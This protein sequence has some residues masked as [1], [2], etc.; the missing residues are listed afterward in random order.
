MDE[1]LK[2]AKDYSPIKAKEYLD[3]YVIKQ[4]KAKIALSM[5]LHSHFKNLKL[6]AINDYCSTMTMSVPRNITFLIGNTG[7]GKSHSIKTL[8][9]YAKL[10][11]VYIDVSKIQ[12]DGYNG[13]NLVSKFKDLYVKTLYTYG[14]DYDEDQCVEMAQYGVVYIDEIDKISTH[15]MEG[16]NSQYRRM[17]QQELL[18]IL[19]GEPI[20]IA[21]N[22]E[23]ITS[24]SETIEFETKNLLIVLSGACVGLEEVIKRRLKKSSP[25]GF[26]TKEEK[27]SI[28]TDEI[29]VE[30]LKEYGF[31]PEILGRINNIIKMDD[32]DKEDLVNILTN[33]KDSIIEKHK[34]SFSLD[35]IKLLFSSKALL[36]IA[37][38]AL[39]KKLG[40][41][42]L[43]TIV[44][45]LL[46][47][48]LYECI[49]NNF[50]NVLINKDLTY[51][52]NFMVKVPDSHIEEEIP[53]E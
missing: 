31:I 39:E 1:L 42:G 13:D 49:K 7:V 53:T 50:C 17:V 20:K 38:R 52:T 9:D 11:S 51:K 41:R 24:T 47:P 35:N 44:E 5:A 32:L 22:D 30:D 6:N 15:G 40:A 33:V 34:F 25:V 19:E 14:A 8:V 28:E 48:L 3:K 27:V 43:K 2:T 16:K 46:N 21:L 29:T 18:S 36:T 26:S 23:K 45:Q 12:P 10:P 37:E 4:D